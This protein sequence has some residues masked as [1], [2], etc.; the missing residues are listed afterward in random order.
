MTETAKALPERK[1]NVF[2]IKERLKK[3][4]EEYITQTL[5]KDVPEDQK[6]FL[7]A[8]CAHLGLDPYKGEIHFI[9]YKEMEYDEKQR[10]KVPTG[11]YVVRPVVSYL[12]YIRRALMT[13]KLAG[14]KVE[15][16]EDNKKTK[17][18]CTIHRKDFEQP[19]VWEVFLDEVKRD[20]STWK[21][22]PLFMLRKVCIAQAFRLA[23]PE[24]TGEL[25]YTEEEVSG[26]REE[27]VE[28]Q[29]VRELPEAPPQ[30]VVETPPENGQ[31]VSAADTSQ[32]PQEPQT[33]ENKEEQAEAAS[34]T[35]EV[36]G[37]F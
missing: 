12:I 36:K 13:G 25:P 9:A 20:T 21:E 24:A 3:V 35:R 28:P 37:L 26:L 32:T 8:L 19:F 17:A 18:V 33:P 23:F 29:V 34:P 10:R 4:A 15:I 2:D 7:I 1:G 5:P 31:A 6:Q 27:V 22:M 14:W 30:T 16:V 11:R